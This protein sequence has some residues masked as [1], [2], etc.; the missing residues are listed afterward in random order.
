[1]SGGSDAEEG[2]RFSTRRSRHRPV[3]PPS[4]GP[5]LPLDSDKI[6]TAETR[7]RVGT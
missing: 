4:V 1:M 5:T 7:F 2:E 6:A 3:S